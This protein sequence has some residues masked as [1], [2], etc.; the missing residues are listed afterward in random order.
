MDKHEILVHIAAPSG[1]R[2]D[3]RYRAQAEAI[4]RFEA[5]VVTRV[6]G[7]SEERGEGKEPAALVVS[8]PE[9]HSDIVKET[10]V[11]RR[12]LHLLSK[13]GGLR[14]SSA[15]ERASPARW[16]VTKG[17]TASKY[18]SRPAPNPP[19]KNPLLNRQP[20]QSTI[21]VLNSPDPPRPRTAPAS[22][23]GLR[24]NS[25][26]AG[27]TTRKR[28]RSES[29]SFESIASV[30]PESQQIHNAITAVNSSGS[31]AHYISSSDPGKK[32]ALLGMKYSHAADDEAGVLHKKPRRGEAS[33][34]ENHVTL[35]PSA[36]QAGEQTQPFF[37]RDRSLDWTSSSAPSSS[38]ATTTNTTS[39]AQ[40][41]D[42]AQPFFLR[43]RSL[44]WTS[45]PTPS[46]S[47]ATKTS[48]TPTA[49]ATP[50]ETLPE[51]PR[52]AMSQGTPSAKEVY[53]YQNP[54]S[55]I[56][57]ISQDLSTAPAPSPQSASPSA[58]PSSPPVLTFTPKSLI[59]S[60]P[61][62][63]FPPSPPVGRG[64]YIT[65]VTPVLAV[66]VNRL[67]IAKW[68]RPIH[69]TRDVRVLERGHWHIPITIASQAVV[70]EARAEMSRERKLAKMAKQCNAPT[71]KERWEK[72]L[73]L[74]AERKTRRDVGLSSSPLE[75]GEDGEF[76]ERKRQ[77]LWT[78]EEF[79]RFWATLEECVGEGKWGW[80]IRVFREDLG[81]ACDDARN[82]SDSEP[83]SS[84]ARGAVASDRNQERRVLLKVTTWG[85]VIAHI[86]ILLWLM[87][88]KLTA[89]IPMEWRTGDDTA[90]VKM[91]G[92]RRKHGILGPW[93]Y[94][95]PAGE[96]GFCGI[97][98][99]EED[100]AGDGE[101][102]KAGKA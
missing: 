24:A 3:K 14:A 51:M 4:A 34:S 43:D 69:V 89:Y 87:S 64:G 31:S 20:Q 30:V 83:L 76:A 48:T 26:F 7:G 1:F 98:D 57:L 18:K 2:D 80:G 65:H 73:E 78:E 52:Q 100:A 37:L 6:Y 82:P 13:R 9:G 45:F 91:S 60:L 70:N 53:A 46:S 28:A 15:P 92:Y 99:E 36:A 47:D 66:T 93:V 19:Y 27:W 62:H 11:N 17:H 33:M 5:A 77:D 61:T 86:W 97:A 54:T 49:T 96:K 68:F 56:N 102:G 63:I 84:P 59:S 35:D 94:K 42:Q 85:E 40:T 23:T 79:V 72:R 29:S 25:P 50:S 75:Y 38:E 67:P 16:R 41:E 44:D 71:S 39:A 55:P 90:V 22:D 8:S 95:G 74:E 58:L 32:E 10:P 81:G 88:D 101:A 21:Q 12:G